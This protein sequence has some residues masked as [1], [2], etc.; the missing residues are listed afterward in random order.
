[1]K[2]VGTP[3]QSYI[4]I[5]NSKFHGFAVHAADET[6]AQAE[7][8]AAKQRH[9]GASAHAYAYTYDDYVKFHDG[10]EPGG[11]AGL[12]MME[13]IKKQGISNVICIVSRYY[14]G[15]HL[16]AGGLARAFGLACAAALGNAEIK[17]LKQAR[18][19]W[20][21]V[22]YTLHG[23]IE[24][25]LANSPFVLLDTQ[26]SAG[27]DLHVLVFATDDDGFKQQLSE[28]TSGSV[29]PVIIGEGHY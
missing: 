15:T 17:T 25:W 26:F 21:S 18:E 11:T 22:G 12:P 24:H 1:M 13:I 23:K 27:V 10:G 19:Y 2:T 3:G 29:V 9:P 4:E 16:G 6:V 8:G 14:G 5:K 28:I 20:F 7:I